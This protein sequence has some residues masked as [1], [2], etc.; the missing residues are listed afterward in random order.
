MNFFESQDS[1]KRNTGRLY[2][3]FGLAVVSLIIITNLLFLVVFGFASSEMTSMAAAESF[4][5]NWEMFLVI[6]F[7][8]TGAVLFGSLF[9]IHSLSAG[10]ARV[11][12]ML[13]GKLLLAGTS[14]FKERQVLNVV[15]E[16]AIASGTAVPPVYLLE[17]EGINAFA[18]GYKPGD[19][20]IG[21]SRGAINTLSRDQLQ[22]VVAH[23]FSHILHGDMRINIR[24]IGV[25]H[26]ILILGIVGR[27]L[28]YTQRFSRRSKGSGGQVAIGVGL[29]AIGYVG[30]FFG[31][32]IKAAVSRQREYLADASAVQYTRNPEGIGGALMQIAHSTNH[33]YLKH[34]DSSEISHAL[35]EE[36]APASFMSGLYA[37]HPP[38]EERI[39]AILPRWDGSYDLLKKSAAAEQEPSV[40]QSTEQSKAEKLR[41]VAILAGASGA[42][43]AE[44]MISQ[45]GNPTE[46]N[47]AAAHEQ[48][49]G[50]PTLFLDAAREPSGARAV[51][52]YLLLHSDGA[53]RQA[54]LEFIKQ[55][56]DAGVH[57]EVERLLGSDSSI[58]RASRFAAATI[59]TSSLRQLSKQQYLRFKSNLD[60]LISL[61]GKVS[62]FEWALQK[63]VIKNLDGVLLASASSSM[64]K[65]ELAEATD[66]ASVVMSIIT[67]CD[68]QVGM[69]PSQVFAAGK[70]SLEAKV[71]LIPLASISINLLNDAANELSDLKPLQK[72]KFLK[73]CAAIITADGKIAAIES[74]LLRAV[75]ATIDCPMPPLVV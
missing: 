72:P 1:A 66:A 55:S 64:G 71:E 2:L 73:A 40:G 60:H 15:E 11:A 41:T 37:T 26:G 42:V 29:L 51:I 53:I 62:L 47:L 69:S 33:S 48:I 28:L 35:F 49:E 63:T 61:D 67:Y 65:L 54:Q 68:P 13:D 16:M 7:A 23:E 44:G 45:I 39:K 21:I 34:P 12:E 56:A 59:A 8:V 20:V 70:A 32:L 5:V 4:S 6:S 31:N 38:L 14:D 36:S 52:Y 19:A 43:I 24:L 50:I 3:L 18:A 57:F 17:E 75:A 10:G 58:E 27:H 25:L 22:G 74:E 30:V 9:K 46:K